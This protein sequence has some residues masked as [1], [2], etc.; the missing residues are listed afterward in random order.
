MKEYLSYL[1][2]YEI[3]PEAER[4][5]YDCKTSSV[6]DPAKRRELKIKQYQKEKELRAKIEVCACSITPV[7][8]LS[9]SVN[10][11]QAV[12]KRRNLTSAEEPAS[13]F[14]LIASLLPSDSS[15]KSTDDDEEDPETEDILREA[16]LLLFRLTYTQAQ[17]QLES[18]EQE[19]EL[20]RS[21]PPPPPSSQDPRR[22][23]GKGKEQDEMWK[24]DAPL[25]RGGPDGKGP[26]LD[27]SGK[28]SPWSRN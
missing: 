15:I 8:V 25:P 11:I 28:V 18:L 9:N 27:Q 4:A 6:A 5:L 1:G 7:S 16:T 19:A 12:R 13:E 24:L 17:S 10:T 14:E 26:L 23:N 2:T 21:M 3:I 20:L 22:S